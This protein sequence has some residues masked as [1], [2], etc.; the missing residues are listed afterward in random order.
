MSQRTWFITGVSSGFGRQLTE[1]LLGR[2]DC[3]V[4]TVRDAGKVTDLL[5]RYPGAFHAEVLDVTDR[6]AIR[7]LSSARLPGSDAST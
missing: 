5:A 1:Q 7:E 4:G 6:A 2:G 3:V